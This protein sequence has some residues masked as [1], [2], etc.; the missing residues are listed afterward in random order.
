MGVRLDRSQSSRGL[1]SF[2]FLALIVGISLTVYVKYTQ[3]VVEGWD[4]VAYLYAGERIAAGEAPS[5]CHYYNGA[6]GPYFT[7]AGFNVRM[8]ESECLRLN[9]P[10]GFPILLAVAQVLTGYRNAALYVPALVGVLGIVS[11]FVLGIVLFDRWVGLLGALILALMPTYLQ[12]STSP[13]SDLAAT[14]FSMWGIGLYLWCQSPSVVRSRWSTAGSLV[15]GGL[16]AYGLLIRYASGIALL[17]LMSYILA[18]QGRAAFWRRSNWVFGSVVSLGFVGL[19]LFNRVYYGGYLT[20]GYSPQHGWYAW[21]AFTL[22]YAFGLSPVGGASLRAAFETFGENLGWL[23]IPGVAGFVVMSNHNRLLIA[24]LLLSYTA[25]Y[26]MYAFAPRGVNARLLLPAF[27]SLALAVGHGLRYGLL[28]WPKS[29]RGRLWIS[30]GVVLLVLVLLLPLPGRLDELADR[31]AS[32]ASYVEGIKRLVEG[33]ESNA[34]FLAY[35]TNDAIAYY[36]QRTTLFYRRIPPLNRAMGTYDWSELEG[37]LVRAVNS[38]L[39]M[40]VPVFYVRDSDPPFADSLDILTR[41]FRC[42]LQGTSPPVY[43]VEQV[44]VGL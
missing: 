28:R 22:R 42:S 43:Q 18:T 6:I 14:V 21:P 4:A 3:T 10:P 44:A 23:V 11:T 5:A 7:L 38:L 15:G 34:V 20:T 25:F 12:A 27:P 24:G 31:N 1:W 41:H 2:V 16:V 17:S 32:A 9:Y 40:D 13:W 33:S 26:G 36:G 37:R 19:L 35:G 29:V 8:G 30:F 39:E